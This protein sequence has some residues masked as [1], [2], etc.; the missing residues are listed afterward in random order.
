M[1]PDFS[2]RDFRLTFAGSCLGDLAP[3]DQAAVAGAGGSQH[4]HELGFEKLLVTEI[5]LR[6]L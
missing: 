5:E 2:Q 1:N 6:D 3:A 4:F